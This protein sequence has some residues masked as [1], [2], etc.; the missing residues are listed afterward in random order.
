MTGRAPTMSQAPRDRQPL[1]QTAFGRAVDDAAGRMA[2]GLMLTVA[3]V[4]SAYVAR[5]A[6]TWT[7]FGFGILGTAI[8]S[9]WVVL[10][11]LL[12]YSAI[13]VAVRELPTA[14]PRHPGLGRKLEI[15]LA[16]MIVVPFIL[17]VA[18]TASKA[19]ENVS[20]L[21]VLGGSQ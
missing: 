15:A 11:L 5:V 2:R 21:T 3:A 13:K 6:Q 4:G 17:A 20:Q 16:G 12:A 18:I 7:L 19:V 14:L 10:Q 9:G 1:Y 8:A